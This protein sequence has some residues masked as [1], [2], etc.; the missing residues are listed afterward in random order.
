[1]TWMWIGVEVRRE[2]AEAV[3]QRRRTGMKVKRLSTISFV[4]EPMD[5]AL[6]KKPVGYSLTGRRLMLTSVTQLSLYLEV[7]TWL[8]LPKDLY[9]P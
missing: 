6:V 4:I 1:M 5:V 9:F 3:A 8:H 2:S 7:S